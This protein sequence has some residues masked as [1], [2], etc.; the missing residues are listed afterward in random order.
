MEITQKGGPVAMDHKKTTRCFGVLTKLNDAELAG[1]EQ[2][3]ERE[4]LPRSQVI[5]RLL[6]REIRAANQPGNN[7]NGSILAR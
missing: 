3:C 1:L 6:M 4:S 7:R 2:L 5:R